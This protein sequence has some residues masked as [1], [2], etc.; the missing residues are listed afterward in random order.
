LLILTGAG[1]KPGAAVVIAVGPPRSEADPVKTV[2]AS[3]TGA[4]RTT[5]R[6]Q[7]GA[8]PGAYVIVACASACRL[9]ATAAFRVT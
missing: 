5:L 1:W 7:R 6:T 8:T 9:R 3:A 2:R 4:L